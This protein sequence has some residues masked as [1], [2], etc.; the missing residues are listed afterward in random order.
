MN[1]RFVIAGICRRIA[2]ILSIPLVPIA[3]FY[4]L[5]VGLQIPSE[6]GSVIGFIL[7]MLFF[8]GMLGGLVIAFWKEGL[9][10]IVSLIAVAGFFVTVWAISGFTR[11]LEISPLAGPIHLL[12]AL[13]IPGYHLDAS[14][15]AKWVPMISWILLITPIGLFFV[16]WALR[17]ERPV[18]A[19]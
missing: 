3:A 14:P 15:I 18:K 9:G 2:R 16:A 6:G 17:R 1:S 5:F 8:L 7:Y 11:L 10:S 19:A 12:F 13:L 4:L